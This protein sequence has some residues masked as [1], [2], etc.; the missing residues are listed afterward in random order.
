MVSPGTAPSCTDGTLIYNGTERTFT[1]TGLTN[2]T[3]YG[4]RLCPVDSAGNIGA[5]STVTTRPTPE[6]NAPTGTVA[7]NG[8]SSSTRLTAVTLTLNASDPS[9]VAKMCIS[10][11]KT[12]TNWEDYNATK[13]WTLTT[14]KGQAV[15]YAWF[16][17]S[18]ANRTKTP[19]SASVLVDPLPPTG[20]SLM[21]T[22][23]VREVNLT[24]SAGTDPSGIAGYKLVYAQGSVAPAS[25][26]AGTML[27]CARTDRT[28]NHANLT[29]G[30]SY[31]YRLCATDS[32]GN[33]SLGSIVTAV[34]R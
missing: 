12:C 34:A 5:G 31:S 3:L 1:H 19:V 21:A 27:S 17:D 32:V 16:E 9:G 2:G 23:G 33:T 25:C 7:V 11:T 22:A 29:S 24:W 15:V 14:S 18:Y 28:C 26:A 10:N 8:G 20:V 4:Y 6:L 13:A 30:T